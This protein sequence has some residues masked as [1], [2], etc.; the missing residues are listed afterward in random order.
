MRRLSSTAASFFLLQVAIL[1]SFCHASTEVSASN[2]ASTTLQIKG[3]NHLEVSIVPPTTLQ[4]TQISYNVTYN[5]LGQVVQ[6]PDFD[7]SKNSMGN[8]DSS[9]WYALRNDFTF[10]AYITRTNGGGGVILARGTTLLGSETFQLRCT[11]TGKLKFLIWGSKIG[12]WHGSGNED[13]MDEDVA[14]GQFTNDFDVADTHCCNFGGKYTFA[15]LNNKFPYWVHE[16]MKYKLI[17]SGKCTDDLDWS[18]ASFSDCQEYAN[19]QSKVLKTTSTS[20]LGCSA[21]AQNIYWNTNKMM[22]DC[23]PSSV[24][25]CVCTAVPSKNNNKKKVL[26]EISTVHRDDPKW[27]LMWLESSNNIG[28][29]EKGYSKRWTDLQGFAHAYTTNN[30]PYI[31]EWK[32]WKDSE[33]VVANQHLV[34]GFQYKVQTKETL[35]GKRTHVAL[36][37][38]SSTF[39]LYLDGVLERSVFMS[40]IYND[41]PLRVHSTKSTKTACHAIDVEYS[42]LN[43][44]DAR[45]HF[46][47]EPCTWCCGDACIPTGNTNKCEPTIWLQKQKWSGKGQ[48]KAWKFVPASNTCDSSDSAKIAL[49]M[50]ALT[51]GA[52]KNDA[53]SWIDSFGGKIEQAKIYNQVLTLDTIKMFTRQ[54]TLVYNPTNTQKIISKE[55]FHEYVG[56]LRGINIKAVSTAIGMKSSDYYES[57]ISGNSIG[58]TLPDPPKLVSIRSLPSDNIN[59]VFKGHSGCTS[60]NPC[61]MCEGNCDADNDCAGSLICFQRENGHESVPGCTARNSVYLGKINYCVNPDIS[62]N[63]NLQ[64]L[65]QPYD[66][67]KTVFKGDSGCTSDNP[68][69]MCEGDCDADND[70]AGSL[71]CVLSASGGGVP[72]CDVAGASNDADYCTLMSQII[73]NTRVKR[74]NIKQ[75]VMQNAPRDWENSEQE[76]KR[77]GPTCHLASIHSEE[78]NDIVKNMISTKS[79]LGLKSQYGLNKWKHSDGSPTK[80]FK[81]AS[82]STSGFSFKPDGPYKNEKGGVDPVCAQMYPNKKNGQTTEDETFGS[83]DDIHCSTNSLPSVCKCTHQIGT[84]HL[85]LEQKN[86][87]EAA[88]DIFGYKVIATRG[89]LIVGS[90]GHVPLGCSVCTGGDFAAHWNTG[91]NHN[92]PVTDGAYTS[93]LSQKETITHT[94]SVKNAETSPTRLYVESCSSIGCSTTVGREVISHHQRQCKLNYCNA[95]H[96]NLEGV[97][98]LQKRYCGDQTCTTDQHADACYFHWKMVSSGKQVFETVRSPTAHSSTSSNPDACMLENYATASTAV[99]SPP[100]SV[101]A[102]IH[103][104]NTVKILIENP[105]DDGGA[106][107]T[108]YTWKRLVAS[109]WIPSYQFSESEQWIEELG[110]FTTPGDQ[111]ILNF[112]RVMLECESTTT[113]L[114]R[115]LFF[116]EELSSLNQIK[117]ET[118][119]QLG[120]SDEVN[121]PETIGV[122]AQRSYTEWH[123]ADSSYKR[124]ILRKNE[125]H[126]VLDYQNQL[127]GGANDNK[128]LG[129]FARIWVYHVLPIHERS[130][131]G[132]PTVMVTIPGVVLNPPTI[133]IE[134]C[135]KFGCSKAATNASWAEQSICS[136]GMYSDLKMGCQNM[137]VRT[138]PVGEGFHSSSARYLLFGSTADD[139][140]C[141]AC[142]LGKYKI[143]PTPSSCISCPGGYFND[144]L[145]SPSCKACPKGFFS[146][147]N[148]K[149]KEACGACDAGT[150]SETKAVICI[151]CPDGYFNDQ[152]NAYSCEECPKGFYS[153]TNNEEK[154]A[155]DACVPGTYSD[156]TKAT[157]ATTCQLCALGAYQHSSGSS[158]CI[159]CPAGKKLT[160]SGAS[161]DHDS[162]NDCED[163]PLFQ[164]S[165]VEGLSEECYPCVTARVKGS[166]DCDGCNPGKYKNASGECNDC[167]IGYYTS[168]QNQ[169]RCTDCPA[170]YF[171]NGNTNNNVESVRYDRCQS[172]PRGKHGTKIR[173]KDVVDG[174]S[175]CTSGKFSE[176]EAI[177]SEIH[178]KGCPKGTWSSDVGVTKESACISCGTG[179]YGWVYNGAS[180]ET[181]CTKCGEGKY[182]SKVGSYGVQSCNACPLGFVQQFQ[183]MAFC[184]PCKP[185]TYNSQLGQSECSHCAEGRYSTQVGR[186]IECDPCSKGLYQPYRGSTSCLNC[187]IGQYQTM[188]EQISCKTCQ[189][190]RA[191]SVVANENECNKCPA[192]FSQNE[193]GQAACLKCNKGEFTNISGSISCQLCLQS[194]YSSSTGRNTSCLRCPLGWSSDIGSAKCRS[195]GAG[196]F[197]NGCKSCPLGYARNGVDPDASK[198]KKCPLGETTSMTGAAACEKC[199]LGR[200]GT[201]RYG[202]SSGTLC[203][204]CPS[205][206][207][208][209]TKGKVKCVQCILGERFINVKTSCSKCDLGKYG[210]SNGTCMDC[211]PGQYQ[212]GKGETSCKECDVDSYLPYSGMSSKNDCIRCALNRTTGT[213]KK[214]T[215]KNACLCKMETSFQDFKNDACVEC[216]SGAVCPII[217]SDLMHLHPMSGYWQPDNTTTEF[218]DCGSAFAD[219]KLAEKARSQC[220]PPSLIKRCDQ[221]PRTSLWTVDHQCLPGYAGPLC[222]AC[223]PKFVLYQGECI[224]CESGSPLWVGVLGLLGV[225]IVLFFISLIVLKKTTTS[226]DQVLETKTGRITGLSSII[227]SWLQILSA[228]TIT[229]NIGWPSNFATYSKSTGT[230]VNLDLMT[231]LS[232]ASCQLAVPF[233]NKFLL[234]ILTPPFLTTAVVLA[235]LMLKMFHG[236]QTGWR[237]VQK[238]RSEQAQSIIIIVVQLVY[239]KLATAT[240]RMFRCVDFGPRIGYLLDADFGKECFK[241]VHAQ[242]VPFAFMSALFYLVGIPMGTFI[243]LYSH[244]KQLHLPHVESRYGG[245]IMDGNCNYKMFVSSVTYCYTFFSLQHIRFVP[246]V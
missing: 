138:C 10:S 88:I 221:V 42:C 29:K 80:Y 184:L 34:I 211:S 148:D 200:Y 176:L 218:I 160:A 233:I 93:I 235:W 146:S 11:S 8:E 219:I 78:E 96:R 98:S 73:A 245:K 53:T 72:G 38:T 188:L 43:S 15:L 177:P 142:S 13:T 84:T 162:I 60:D 223:A 16:P 175:N 136:P 127:I 153:S 131:K 35:D 18:F 44:I 65:I 145:S 125:I 165:P 49:E 202:K 77:H 1:S 234:Q 198:C 183:G 186:N 28:W 173:A 126:C 222:V 174:C 91:N 158:S 172:C 86:C 71:T 40:S 76:C 181:F 69:G 210:S 112:S 225:S 20:T 108:H 164:F 47:D 169:K 139:G 156:Q 134:A 51:I 6:F 238:A 232:L 196:T 103:D 79:W 50:E 135:N 199:D 23:H 41:D 9:G 205:G 67:I 120:F 241:G 236:K 192:G 194:T 187:P 95:H 178:C 57:R 117:K 243:A 68:C 220:C 163:C 157:L 152:L 159:L 63:T 99:P 197:G 231:I 48:N 133:Q 118:S 209:D 224:P 114:H 206:F 226:P 132:V 215:S 66:K 240:F 58:T 82:S 12:S 170:G 14:N 45:E 124:F 101:S 203:L 179:K 141:T 81:W 31:A 230:I 59:I 239:P 130:G 246:A 54:D 32:V 207:Y 213:R 171:A 74:Y 25:K 46:M 61:G 122:D 128:L 19:L 17:D 217:G 62:G 24:Q 143:S 228:L 166:I 75:Y 105:K 7:Q 104:F 121:V 208:Q 227:V 21:D 90:W 191:S 116:H 229:Y 147:N 109:H 214:C 97:E 92:N 107:I 123:A 36:V 111:S 204:E 150:Y 52:A 161:E 115:T 137:T 185:G 3:I 216:P 56:L 167:P 83:Y 140:S 87:L 149:E 193:R 244:R 242:Y 113:R 119:D 180:A 151:S 201:S 89:T 4:Q 102:S 212:D 100:A 110:S 22:G 195:C 129:K 85:E 33:Y 237:K 5:V 55:V 2:I 30:D 106:N 70:C 182:L 64:V 155:C 154:K 39:K 190:G 168:K 26:I 189:A 144:Q 27:A 37:R 94:I